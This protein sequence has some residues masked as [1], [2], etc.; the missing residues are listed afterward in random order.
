M[1]SNVIIGRRDLQQFCNDLLKVS[2]KFA[3]ELEELFS[4]K[5]VHAALQSMEGGKTPGVDELPN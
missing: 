5:E 3:E 4:L 2:V 1:V